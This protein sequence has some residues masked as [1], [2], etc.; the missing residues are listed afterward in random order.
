MCAGFNTTCRINDFRQR[1]PQEP[2]PHVQVGAHAYRHLQRHRP[3][4]GSENGA[5]RRHVRKPPWRTPPRAAGK[6]GFARGDRPFSQ[7][8]VQ[9][10]Q[11]IVKF[12]NVPTASN[13]SKAGKRGFSAIV[14]HLVGC[15]R[16]GPSRVRSPG[17]RAAMKPGMEKPGS[18]RAPSSHLRLSTL[19][20]H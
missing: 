8:A 12:R 13:A 17:C 3:F 11:A 1:R 9:L 14:T 5:S 2:S 6:H 20:S 10:T 19:Q 7:N 16:S 4:A 15:R 18:C